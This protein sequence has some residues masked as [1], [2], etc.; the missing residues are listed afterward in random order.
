[1]NK[2]SHLTQAHADRVSVPPHVQQAEYA[3]ANA[4]LNALLREWSDWSFLSSQQQ[5][6]LSFDEETVRLPLADNACLLVKIPS[7]PP[8]CKGL[9]GHGASYNPS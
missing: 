4:F 1:M 7:H 2:T 6:L 9:S 8:L 3:T 5:E